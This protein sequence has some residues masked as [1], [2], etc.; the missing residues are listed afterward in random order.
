[1]VNGAGTGSFVNYVLPFTSSIFQHMLIYLINYLAEPR[2]NVETN[3]FCLARSTIE[4]KFHIEDGL[5][6]VTLI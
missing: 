1:M 4:Y 3:N 5:I 2:G 6:N